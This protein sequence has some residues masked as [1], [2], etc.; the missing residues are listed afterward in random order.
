VIEGLTRR[1]DNTLVL[2]SFTEHID[3]FWLRG[4]LDDTTTPWYLAHDIETGFDWGADETI[5]QDFGTDIVYITLLYGNCHRV[6]FQLLDLGP[7]NQVQREKTQS[8]STS[9]TCISCNVRDTSPTLQDQKLIH[10]TNT[11]RTC[12]FRKIHVHQYEKT[13]NKIGIIPRLTRL[14]H[15]CDVTHSN[16]WHDSFTSVTWLLH[17]CAMPRSHVWHASCICVPPLVHRCDVTYANVWHDS[18]TCVTWLMHMYDTTDSP[19]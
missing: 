4:W 12:M 10:V 5:P 7:G 3:L 11:S 14:V 15:M 13:L 16:V 6:R 1:Y 9:R 17:V 2:E 8:R 18:F 19:V